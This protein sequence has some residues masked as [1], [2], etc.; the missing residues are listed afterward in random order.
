[1]DEA[2]LTLLVAIHHQLTT[3]SDLESVSAPHKYSAL[4]RRIEQALQ[5]TEYSYLC[6][7]LHEE[8]A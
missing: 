2:T 3:D 1:M 5:G 4:V 8:A 6:N 7:H